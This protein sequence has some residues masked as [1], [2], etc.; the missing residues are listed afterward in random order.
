MTCAY[1]CIRIVSI[2]PVI[3][4][5]NLDFDFCFGQKCILTI[6]LLFAISITVSKDYRQYNQF[7]FGRIDFAKTKLLLLIHLLI[8]RIEM[9]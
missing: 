8:H 9:L 4:T 2:T 3:V 5:L 7:S 1:F 6:L